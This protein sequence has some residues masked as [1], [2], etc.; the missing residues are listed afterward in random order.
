MTTSIP[1]GPV[2]TRDEL[3]AA[4]KAAGVWWH[5]IDLGQGVVTPGVKGAAAIERE[6]RSLRLPDLAGKT[7]LDIGAYDGY[8]SF[9]AERMKA[10]RVLALDRFAW[11]HDF[12]AFSAYRNDCIARGVEPLPIEQTPHWQPESLPGKRAFDT[13]HWALGSKVETRVDEFMDMDVSTLGSFDV[14]L[15]LGVLYHMKDPLESLR[16]LAQVTREV[17]VI[18]TH[19]ISIFGREHL[20]LCE[21]YSGT[22]LMGDSTNWWG[23]NLKAAVG[24]CRAAGFSRVEVVAGRVPAGLVPKMRRIAGTALAV[25]NRRPLYFRAVLHAWK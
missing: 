14:T 17:A 20:E 16:R 18:E 21:F 7:V 6:L 10:A 5:S 22:Q 2:R 19:A 12:P 8:Y 23:P 15:F 9:A 13:A 4:V 11:S 1:S 24:M 25:V 3:L